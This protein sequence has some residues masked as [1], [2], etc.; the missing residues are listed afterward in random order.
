MTLL[1]GIKGVVLVR[2]DSDSSLGS[3]GAWAWILQTSQPMMVMATALAA[4]EC[5]HHAAHHEILKYCQSTSKVHAEVP[6][7]LRVRHEDLQGRP[8]SFVQLR[9]VW[10]CDEVAWTVN[11][12][13]NFI[14]SSAV[15]WHTTLPDEQ[16]LSCQH[17]LFCNGQK[18]QMKDGNFAIWTSNLSHSNTRF[19]SVQPHKYDVA[20]G[21]SQI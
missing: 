11:C 20:S 4:N 17:H 5:H 19:Q 14:H 7:N 1:L 13:S 12:A 15:C 21:L 2:P 16:Y 18:C 3:C 8:S 10:W 6:Q 9:A